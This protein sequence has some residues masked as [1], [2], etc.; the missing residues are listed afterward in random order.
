MPKTSSASTVAKILA[1]ATSSNPTEA[2]QGIEQAYRRMVRDGVTLSDLLNLELSEL[3]QDTLVRLVDVILDN[4]PDL[5]PAARRDAYSQY[6]AMIVLR[7]AGVKPDGHGSASSDSG[8]GSTS[9]R[10]SREEEAKSY[11][12][13][14]SSG[15][16]APEPPR[17]AGRRS[18]TEDKEFKHSKVKTPK[19]EAKERGPWEF[20]VAGKTF[21]FSPAGFKASV[22]DV[23]GPG[24]I[25]WHAFRDPLR[26]VR[27][28]AAAMLWGFGF[29]GVI[30]FAFASFHALLGIRPLVDFKVER[31]FSLLSAIGFMWKTWQLY[32]A[33]WFR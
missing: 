4:Q 8:T 17:G 21:A 20:R 24:S 29:A 30:L 11:R 12:E 22:A 5:S 7:F 13:R 19:A 15:S 9:S 1:R 10:Q 2:K 28:W 31:A 18:A 16:P 23:F 3:Y 25:L 26:A 32:R 33:G 27:L 14:T 6:M